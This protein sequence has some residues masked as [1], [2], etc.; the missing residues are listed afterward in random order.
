MVRRNAFTMI[1]LIL[2]IVI[3]AVAFLSIP[4]L[5]NI[6]A[7]NI[8]TSI[9]QEAIFIAI[10]KL[11]QV[12]TQSW[13]ENSNDST[14]TTEYSKVVDISGGTAALARV[15]TSVFRAGHIQESKHR[16]FFTVADN[17]SA[18]YPLAI[19]GSND[20]DDF[21]V[22]NAVIIN[23]PG[24]E[25]YKKSYR[26]D[27]AVEY[28]SDNSAI[29]GGNT[30][31]NSQIPTFVFDTT[32]AGTATN[33]KMI[34]TTIEQENSGNYEPVIVFRTYSCNIGEVDFYSKRY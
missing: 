11:N 6:N 23:E 15:D 9:S 29:G 10:T 7:R 16:R 32:A 19:E 24:L 12:L 13:D 1:E 25:G 17:R 31:F 26:I 20:M 30:N 3:I 18:S 4:V 8:H 28:V 14:A 34:E 27:I 22:N 21:V 5:L 2:A 33:M